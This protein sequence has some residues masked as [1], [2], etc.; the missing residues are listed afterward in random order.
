VI[1]YFGRFIENYRYSL[2]SGVTFVHIS[3]VRVLHQ[4]WQKMGWAAFWT[5]FSHTHLVTLPP[6]QKLHVYCDWIYYT[7]I[8]HF[9][10]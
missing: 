5:T 8:F 4:F 1:V 10:L 2:H 7:L 6:V 3:T 9:F